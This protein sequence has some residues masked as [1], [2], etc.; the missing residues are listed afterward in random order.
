MDWTF[1]NLPRRD[2]NPS[3]PANSSTPAGA[4]E[5]DHNNEAAQILARS[6]IH[7]MNTNVPRETINNVNI[8][9]PVFHGREHEDP[10]IFLHRLRKYFDKNQIQ[11]EEDRVAIASSQLK[12]EA[13]KWYEHYQNLYMTFQ[14]FQD[15][16]KG[17]Y[18]SASVLANARSR[19]Y[20]EKQKESEPVAVFIM[21]K[22][23]LFNRLDPHIPEDTM[24]SIIIELLNPEIRSRLRTSYFQQPEELIEAATVIEQDLEII[25]Q[26][27]R[28]QQ[29]REAA[30]PYPLRG[31][32]NNRNVA[33]Q[34]P[35]PRPST[36]T[37]TRTPLRS[38]ELCRRCDGR[39]YF[40][41][42]P[43]RQ[44]NFQGNGG[45]VHI[46][47]NTVTSN[48]VK[49]QNIP[50][51]TDE[52]SLATDIAIQGY[53]AKS[54]TLITN[55]L[56]RIKIQIQDAFYLALV[57]SG[58]ATNAIRATLLPK[59]NNPKPK[60]IQLACGTTEVITH[61]E[62]E[63]P[64]RIGPET[65]PVKF[66][67]IT[68]LNEPIILGTPFLHQY[69]IFI[70]FQRKCLHFGVQQRRTIYWD[71]VKRPSREQ[72]TSPPELRIPETHQ[73]LFKPILEE[74]VD[75]FQENPSQPTTATTKH[76]I[77]LTEKKDDQ[78]KTISN[79][80]S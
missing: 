43:L 8:P 28:R 49:K 29:Y 52:E 79:D 69:H 21:R 70:D 9:L 74:F 56:P 58:A 54:D 36:S 40:R 65:L 20:G 26:T 41:D 61:G 67:V 32:H 33:Q 57:D 19:L 64:I 76:T 78:S 15:R 75:L 47:I 13:A 66:Q 77:V 38:P 60:K 6:L 11:D 80:S 48:L 31:S 63:I 4:R 37:D 34:E 7:M 18:N 24:V 46:P 39:H 59:I 72:A 71:A 1:R 44:E 2:E 12:G 73:A 55:Q 25:R 35:Y 14:R 42:C 17:K 3:Q 50:I 53:I 5:P 30:P 23:S 16:L 27:H 45:Q 51:Q 68:G 62:T 10:E 22:T